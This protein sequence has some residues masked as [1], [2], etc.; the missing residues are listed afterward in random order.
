MVLIDHHRA[1]GDRQADGAAWWLA[2]RVV[3]RKTV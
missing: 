3:L 1:E 2:L